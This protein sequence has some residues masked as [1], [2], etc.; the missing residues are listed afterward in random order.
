[1]DLTREEFAALLHLP[2]TSA[3]NLRLYETGR[4]VPPPDAAPLLVAQLAL[5][6]RLPESFF[7]GERKEPITSVE[8]RVERLLGEVSALRRDVALQHGAEVLGEAGD[9]PA[10]AASPA[11]GRR[12]SR[13]R[14][15]R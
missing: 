13:S 1:M 9:P 8:I 14:R 3:P 2:G 5:L 10:G 4:S 12:R 11:N 6:S 7:W 15:P